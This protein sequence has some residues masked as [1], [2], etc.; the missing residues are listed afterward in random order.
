MPR[1]FDRR[2]PSGSAA[3]WLASL[4]FLLP[5]PCGAQDSHEFLPEV[6]LSVR[7][8]PAV[9][10]IVI[11]SVT[12][13]RDTKYTEATIGAH[14]DFPFNKHFSVRPGYWHVASISHD[15]ETYSE[16][17][18][19]LDATIKFPLGAG[20]R[21]ADRNRGDLRDIGAEWSQRY[22][23]R[24]RFER[25]VK[26]RHELLPYFSAEASYDSR[27]D[28]WN[29]KEYTLGCEVDLGSDSGLDFSVARQLD[30]QN[31]VKKLNAFGITWTIGFAL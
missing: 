10:M 12:R 26:T 15:D 5:I 6:D 25:P 27:Y 13:S 17:R 14:F 7:L 24:L 21:A 30:P 9:R 29:R 18:L 4:F 11:G 2:V 8:S 23:N 1:E 16:N 31:P 19:M 22:R 20:F 3:M 28:R